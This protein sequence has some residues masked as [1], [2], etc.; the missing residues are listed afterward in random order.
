MDQNCHLRRRDGALLIDR[1]LDYPLSSSDSVFFF[2]GCISLTL[3]F[4]LES[5]LSPSAVDS[6]GTAFGLGSSINDGFSIGGNVR[7]GGKTVA[8]SSDFGESAKGFA[9]GDVDGLF[10]EAIDRPAGLGSIL[11]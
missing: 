1:I 3:V 6:V 5:E 8:G 2:V 4:S 10:G 11:G 7:A 9:I